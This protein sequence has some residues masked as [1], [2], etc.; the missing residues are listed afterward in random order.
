MSFWL[1]SRAMDRA[2]LPSCKKRRNER[3]MGLAGF[4]KKKRKNRQTEKGRETYAYIIG[5][6][7][8]TAW[9]RQ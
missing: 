9:H 1:A 6:S 8:I 3:M 2:V 7:S 4:V 5:E